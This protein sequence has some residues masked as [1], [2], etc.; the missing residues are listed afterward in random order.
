MRVERADA[1]PVLEEPPEAQ[2]LAERQKLEGPEPLKEKRLSRSDQ[3][4]LERLKL[5]AQHEL[6][7]QLALEKPHE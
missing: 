2:W 6:L 3:K 5:Q 1:K 4:L 7:A